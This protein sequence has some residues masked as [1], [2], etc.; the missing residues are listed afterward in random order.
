MPMSQNK[1]KIGMRQLGLSTSRI[2]FEFLESIVTVLAS[3]WAVYVTI[4]Y[5]TVDNGL[6]VTIFQATSPAIFFQTFLFSFF[7]ASLVGTLTY[8]AG[9][10][11]RGKSWWGVIGLTIGGCLAW[12]Y[13]SDVQ[14]A[15]TGLD[16]LPDKFRVS[17]VIGGAV[18]MG[19]SFG[20][21][22]KYSKNKPPLWFIVT[23]LSLPFL[24]ITLKA[25]AAITLLGLVWLLLLAE[26][27]GFY[28]IQ[29]LNKLF[30]RSG[31]S[32]RPV[33]I[34]NV[35]VGLQF[36]SL[37]VLGLGQVGLTTPVNL[38]VLLALLTLL[39]LKRVG[40]YLTQLSRIRWHQP[41]P[42]SVVESMGLF[43]LTALFAVFWIGVLAPETG[44]DA[45]GVRVALP[46][47][48]LRQGRISAIPAMTGSY[49]AITGEIIYLLIMP[50]AGLMAA[51]VIQ[52]GLAVL[53][54]ASA[55]VDIF[56]FRSRGNLPVWLLGFW[57]STI[58]W[59]Q[60]FHGFTDLTQLF[61]YYSCLLALW[62]WLDQTNQ[63]LWLIISGILGA[64]ATTVK[65]NGAGAL[66]IVGLIVV[67]VTLYQTRSANQLLKNGLTLALPVALCL[68]PWWTRSYLLTGNPIFPFANGFFK[69]PLVQAE[70]VAVHYGVGLA[71][72]DILTV[73][74]G[75]FFEPT[76]FVETGTYNPFLL[77]MIFL[78]LTGTLSRPGKD[79]FWFLVGG[80]AFLTWL[81]TEQN[82]RYSIY[83][84]YL[85]AVGIS[86]GL[87]KL[88][89]RLNDHRQQ[90][91]FQ[92]VMLVIIL[93]G[94][95]IQT[96]RPNFFAASAPA[97]PVFPTQ[98][99]LG[100][101]SA[102]SYLTVFAP[103]YPC[104]EVVNQRY[105]SDAK[106]WQAT[107]R[108]NLYFL[109]EV[110]SPPWPILPLLQPLNELIMEPGLVSDLAELHHRLIAMGYTH[111]MY[112]DNLHY[113]AGIPE[114]KRQG[115]FSLTFEETYLEPECANRGVRLYRIRPTSVDPTFK[116]LNR[117]PNLLQNPGFELLNELR[118]PDSWEIVGHPTVLKIAG[119][120]LVG[121][122]SSDSLFQAVPVQEG[123]LYELKMEMAVEE[124]GKTGNLQIS[125]LNQAGQL[126]LFYGERVSPFYE[127]APFRFLQT[128]PSGA[129]QAVIYITGDRV[130]VD[131]IN[132]SEV[133]STPDL[134]DE[135]Q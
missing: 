47:I 78:A 60:L 100:T 104:A 39:C 90:I 89:D 33:S 4:S 35:A 26:A 69:S 74:W 20:L 130:G 19:G 133:L 1:E 54:V 84:V 59:W 12:I 55:Y 65:F 28:L 103:S 7:G 40:A 14:V 114:E 91:T 71:F 82:T 42:L 49:M 2:K 85:L 61:F 56:K 6:L 119:N 129:Q 27:V 109:A 127:L 36:L 5:F 21:A 58:I 110:F 50:L 72:P 13:W 29:I 23:L 94:F 11:F 135:V 98:V 67:I 122:T 99:V 30:N 68:L 105:G 118:Q 86:L 31:E 124:Q 108:D 53:L 80:L 134:P 120:T 81:V 18:I 97:G 9:H 111:L 75:I 101:Q 73:P 37:A 32:L 24:L 83:A 88:Y 3:V 93:L 45:L 116:H 64:A 77:A 112:V 15:W 10:N 38:V 132:F 128:A 70:L 113:L 102:E 48:Y 115:V 76:R 66:L 96:L 87:S 17:F 62:F 92:V 106:I 79:I 41:V 16:N 121:V 34:L 51:K 44:P 123:H 52:F 8:T 46:A 107:L 43:A 63:P 126:F 95:W 117:G 125:W 25:G 57:G 22:S 131:N